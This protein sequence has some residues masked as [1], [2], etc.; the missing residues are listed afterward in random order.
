[1]AGRSVEERVEILEQ[2][3][4]SLEQLP[5]KVTELT[6]K[7]DTLTTE[8]SQFRAENDEAHS[9][10]RTYIGQMHELAVSQVVTFR[11]ELK[12]D[13]GVLRSQMVRRFDAVETRFDRLDKQFAEVLKRLPAAPLG[14]P[15]GE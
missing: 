13:V 2:T 5:E 15:E 4:G 12:A 1:M 14:G 11:D 8:F 10:T 6:T 9:A 3:V 7:V